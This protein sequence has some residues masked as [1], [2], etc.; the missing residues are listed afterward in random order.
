MKIFK[1][2]Y[3]FKPKEFQILYFKQ[4]YPKQNKNQIKIIYKN[5]LYS[6]IKFKNIEDEQ[7]KYKIKFIIFETSFSYNKLNKGDNKSLLKFNEIDNSKKINYKCNN[8]LEFIGEQIFKTVYN[9]KERDNLINIFGSGFV[10]NNKDK[11]NIMYNNKL[12]PLKDEFLINDIDIK[13]KNNKKLEIILIK[14][15]FNYVYNYL[16]HKNNN[17]DVQINMINIEE[18][19]LSEYEDEFNEYNSGY[20]INSSINSDKIYI[21][22]LYISYITSKTSESN[23]SI[24][25]EKLLP[26]SGENNIYESNKISLLYEQ[27]SL[28]SFLDVSNIFKLYPNSYNLSS[29]Y[30]E[31]IGAMFSGCS[32]LISLSNVSNWNTSHLKDMSNLFYGCSSLISLSDI[33]N[34]NIS[35]VEDMRYMF[36]GCT[37]LISLPDISNWNTSNVINMN[38]M[39][40][41]CSSLISL[42]NI[43][44]WNTSNVNNMNGMF[45]E[46]SSLMSLPDISNW[47]LSNVKDIRAL[48]S[49]CASLISFPDISNW[50]TSNINNMRFLFIGC[51]SLVSLPDISNWNTSNVKDM[52]GIFGRCPSLI[53]LPNISKW[54]T[55]NVVNISEM[56]YGCSSLIS[57]PD[58]SNWNLS[59]VE[60][61]EKIFNECLSLISLPDIPI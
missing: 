5:K 58:I 29:N 31:N 15:K 57:L 35:N 2:V 40:G 1:S 43:S 24:S 14:S 20:K 8:I 30:I 13:D 6:L 18:R 45:W 33:S 46:C 39:F 41:L 53:S 59:N 42:P 26:F 17:Y 50:D 22:S 23:S 32:S 48:F 51:S 10:E 34:W 61:M 38:E 12:F 36:Y 9:I 52:G 11:Y 3:E 28:I 56:F 4:N 27:S 55:S 49:R 7:K 37:S 19:S 44:R 16:N 21:E 60:D 47:N 54:D 25:E